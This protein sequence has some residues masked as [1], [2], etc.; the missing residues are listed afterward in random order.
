MS[1]RVHPLCVVML[2][3]A[4]LLGG[5]ED[6]PS[7][8]PIDVVEFRLSEDTGRLLIHQQ[9]QQQYS[10]LGYQII[11]KDFTEP[12]SVRPTFRIDLLGI[13]PPAG[14]CAAMPGPATSVSSLALP[15]IGTHNIEIT[16]NNTVVTAILE[17]TSDSLVVTG[18]N[19]TWTL[20][21]EP[22]VARP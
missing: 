20:W 7:L 21:P 16:I 2:L 10:C 15:T 22:R 6:S 3:V 14:T 8:L 18:G 4:P 19:S 1:H 13:Q 12:G 5:C 11:H 17:V 9:T